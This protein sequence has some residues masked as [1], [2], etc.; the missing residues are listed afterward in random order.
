MVH[1]LL[2]TGHGLWFVVHGLWFVVHG[3]QFTVH[4]LALPR[5]WFYL[6]NID[7]VHATR[8]RGSAKP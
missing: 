1:G 4:G 3:S 2:F 5:Q 6:Q 8:W 7:D